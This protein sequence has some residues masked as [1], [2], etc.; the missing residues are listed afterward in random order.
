MHGEM[1]RVNK[2]GVKIFWLKRSIMLRAFF[3]KNTAFANHF[4]TKYF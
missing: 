1:H 3:L 2:W 4:F